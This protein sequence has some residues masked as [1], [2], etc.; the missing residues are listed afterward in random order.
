MRVEIDPRSLPATGAWREGDPAG[1]RQFADLGLVE[2]ESGE[3]LP[4]TVAY[5]TWGELAPD[6]SNA[7][8]VL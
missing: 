8:L 6:G 7:V 5:E 1:G 3:D 4:V 2:L